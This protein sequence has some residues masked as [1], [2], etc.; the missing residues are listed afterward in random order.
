MPKVNRVLAQM[1]QFTESVRSGEWKGYSGKAI[2]DVI[3]VGIGGSDLVSQTK[4]CDF[5]L[6]SFNFINF[7]N[8]KDSKDVKWMIEVAN[9]YMQE[10]QV[11]LKSVGGENHLLL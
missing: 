6:I 10:A 4:Q 5:N 1:R 3:N 2:T 8:V 7:T 9:T 11:I